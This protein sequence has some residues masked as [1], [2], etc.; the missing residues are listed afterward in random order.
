[1]SNQSG[2]TEARALPEYVAAY[3]L[4]AFKD[5]QSALNRQP[6]FP[7]HASR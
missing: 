3:A 4:H 5:A 1:M 7:A 2:R 6:D